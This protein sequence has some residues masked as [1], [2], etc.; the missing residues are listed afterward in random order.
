[1]L[2]GGC[3]TNTA[4][5]MAAGCRGA[6]TMALQPTTIGVMMDECGRRLKTGGNEI[7]SI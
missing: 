2:S 1:M 4:G 3:I 6:P 7:I 5:D